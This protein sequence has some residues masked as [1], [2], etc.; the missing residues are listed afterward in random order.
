[1]TDGKSKRFLKEEAVPTIF[2]FAPD[3]KENVKNL[4]LVIL[5]NVSKNCVLKKLFPA[6]KTWLFYKED[7]Q[8]LKLT[9]EKSIGMKSVITADKAV[10][11]N[12]S[13]KSVHTQYNPLN[14]LNTLEKTET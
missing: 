14:V 8:E 3:P 2:N 7:I 9:S 11:N 13:T 4:Q 5:K 6:I 12:P 1:M 10:G